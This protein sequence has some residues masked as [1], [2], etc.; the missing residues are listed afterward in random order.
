MKS[1]TPPWWRLRPRLR[2][3]WHDR[4]PLADTLTLAQR[5]V[6]ILP[7]R[8]G[9]MLAVTLGVLLVASI[10]YQLNLGYLLT[11]MLSGCVVVGMVVSH[12]TLRGLKLHLLPPAPLF[13]G[14]LAV[15]DLRLSNDRRSPRHAIGMAVEGTGH[16]AW[17][18]VPAQGE[19]ALQISF[20][21]TR[22]GLHRVPVLTT[23]TRFPLGTFRVWALW[24]PLAQVLV[25]PAPE[26][27]PPP[28]PPG[29]PLSGTGAAA[30]ARS[31]EEFDGV[32]AYQRGDPMK[33]VVWKKFAKSGELVSRDATQAQRYELWLD[34][35]RAGSLDAEG[36]LSR[37]VAWVLA[38]DAQ[39]LDYGLRLPG[40]EIKPGGGM[41]QR[42]RALQALATC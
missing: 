26:Q 19:A 36:R 11:F 18:D 28:L 39:G 31:S 30:G 24:R 25:Y 37:L 5:N 27:Q 34:F 35:A 22:R 10:N 40:M 8:A 32:R 1:T 38:A 29:E 20:R 16:W 3:W 15:L 33:L 12:N 13:A 7:T 42:L 4:L 41:A 17:A 21:P 9:W 23:E 6:Y 14:H 2:Q